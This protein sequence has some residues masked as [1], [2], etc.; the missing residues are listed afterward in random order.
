MQINKTFLNDQI[1]NKETHKQPTPVGVCSKDQAEHLKEETQHLMMSVAARLLAVMTA[2][3]C[4]P[5]I[6][7]N[8]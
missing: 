7:N 8:H 6:K 2:K 3:N 5:S 1:E 4:Y